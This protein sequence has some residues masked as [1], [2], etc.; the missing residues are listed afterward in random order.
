MSRWSISQKMNV[1]KKHVDVQYT[2]ILK[3]KK[4]DRKPI[5]CGKLFISWS[6]IVRFSIVEFSQPGK[7]IVSNVQ[8]FLAARVYVSEAARRTECVVCARACA[9]ARTDRLETHT[10][11]HKT[12]KKNE[13]IRVTYLLQAVSRRIEQT[14]SDSCGGIWY[15]WKAE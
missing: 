12:R 13:C 11:V 8:S 7:S 10:H 6:C 5:K 14:T 4:S 9:C 15:T 2:G 3:K 1:V